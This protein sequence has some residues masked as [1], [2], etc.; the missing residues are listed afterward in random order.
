MDSDLSILFLSQMHC[1]GEHGKAAA[2]LRANM[3]LDARSACTGAESY[4]NYP[5][6]YG[7]MVSKRKLKPL[8]KDFDAVILEEGIPAW[9]GLKS[10]DLDGKIVVRDAHG[11]LT[12]RLYQDIRK[13]WHGPTMY[14]TPDL[15]AYCY[16]ETAYFPCTLDL[17]RFPYYASAIGEQAFEVAHAPSNTRIKGSKLLEQAALDLDIKVLW[18]QGEPNSI[19]LHRRRKS[20]VYFDNIADGSYYGYKGVL[21]VAGIE[22]AAMGQAVIGDFSAHRGYEPMPEYGTD[23]TNLNALTTKLNMLKAD[24]DLRVKLQSEW[25][26]WVRANRDRN[27]VTRRWLDWLKTQ[28]PYSSA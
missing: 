10:A 7:Y 1:T 8:L 20:T 19:S 28:L 25:C 18:S 15:G 9:Y 11:S 5:N 14:R 3:D 2:W 12:R 16:G 27:K 4:L 26:A 21:G 24:D 23:I 13:E 22:A 17:A 6:D